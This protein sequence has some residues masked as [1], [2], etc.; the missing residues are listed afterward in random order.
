MKE[1]MTEEKALLLIAGV[2][3]ALKKC[4]FNYEDKA[5]YQLL[6]RGDTDGI[7]FL[8]GAFNQFDL[9]QLKPSNLQQLTAACAFSHPLT[10]DL[11][12]KYLKNREI[13]SDGD[14]YG[15]SE[16]DEV[17]RET[18][19]IVI[20]KQQAD[21]ITSRLDKL[22]EEGRTELEPQAGFIK[23][24]LQKHWKW[25]VNRDYIE[26]RAKL[27]YRLA[28]IKV[29][30]HDEFMKLY[31]TLC[32]DTIITTKN[33][34]NKKKCRK[35]YSPQNHPSKYISCR[36]PSFK[37]EWVQRHSCVWSHKPDKHGRTRVAG[38]V[39]QKAKEEIREEIRREI[40]D[41]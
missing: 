23:E 10:N 6:Q 28:Y 34:M 17:L 7:F 5:T 36:C 19:G 31:E 14:Y 15:I 41:D 9:C 30:L 39:R 21:E 13:R 27:V 33:A 18:N 25:L 38:I 1:R 4:D 29:H 2:D 12:Y 3:A 40:Q 37:L 35:D 20:Y 24:D 16:V 32:K 11:I 22:L 26:R 8:E